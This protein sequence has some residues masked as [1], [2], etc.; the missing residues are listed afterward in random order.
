MQKIKLSV[1]FF[2]LSTALLAQS[3]SQLWQEIQEPAQPAAQRMIFP[4]EYRVLKLQAEAMLQFLD[5]APD[6]SVA[7][8][9]VSTYT[10]Q[11]PSPDGRMES[12]R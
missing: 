8:A 12:F 11:L 1:L 10:L 6:E 5:G 9:G 7:N 2:W 4:K 3:T